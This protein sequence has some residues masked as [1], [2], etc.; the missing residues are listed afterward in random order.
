MNIEAIRERRFNP[1][2][3]GVLSVLIPGLG[4]L[5][6]GQLIR[7]L[8]WFCVV[9]IGYFLLVVPGI[10]LHVLCVAGAAFGDAGSDRV[11][12]IR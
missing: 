3:A 9:G 11:R 8:V 4:Q 12:L 5:Y 6:K 2:V 7:A 10:I 1:L